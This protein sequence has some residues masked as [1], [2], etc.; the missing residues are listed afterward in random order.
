[1]SVHSLG[2]LTNRQEPGDENFSSARWGAVAGGVGAWVRARCEG[3][4]PRMSQSHSANVHPSIYAVMH[5]K[6]L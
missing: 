3:G 5:I 6:Y 1:M 2:M 4:K